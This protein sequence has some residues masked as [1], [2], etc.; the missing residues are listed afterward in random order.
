MSLFLRLS[1]IS[2]ALY[3]QKV[4]SKVGGSEKKDIKESWT[5]E[6]AFL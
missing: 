3:C 6:E 4:L 2:M 5:Y 1:R